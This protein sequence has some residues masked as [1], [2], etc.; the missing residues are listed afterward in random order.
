MMREAHVEVDITNARQ[1]PTHGGADPASVGPHP[2][3]PQRERVAPGRA[4]L[5]D[6]LAGDLP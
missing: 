1:G 4:Q 2:D 3:R 5:A 6:P